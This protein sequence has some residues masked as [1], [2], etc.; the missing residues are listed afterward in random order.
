MGKFL[1]ILATRE[2]K[3]SKLLKNLV[4]RLVALILLIVLSP[5]LITIAILVIR[6]SRGPAIFVQKRVGAGKR[7]FSLYKFRTMLLPEYSMN[8]KEQIKK[9]GDRITGL[10]NFLRRTSLDE[11]PQLIN[12]LKGDMSLVGPRPTL[13]YQVERYNEIQLRRLDMKPGLTGLAQV[14]GRNS[15]SWEEK[16]LYDVAYIENFSLWLDI[17][18]L[19]KTIK[20][21][22]LRRDIEFVKTDSISE[23]DEG[24]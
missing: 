10:G 18:I 4:D 5:L 21:V 14:K 1:L 15:L 9:D 20:V 19:F 16:I 23:S 24:S 13:L 11:L 22:F 8:G 17:K 12:I 3:M 6:D 2:G 7:L